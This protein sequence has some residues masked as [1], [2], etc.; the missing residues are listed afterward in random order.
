MLT[1]TQTYIYTYT[2]IYTCDTNLSCG[3]AHIFEQHGERVS[4]MNAIAVF[5]IDCLSQ[6]RNREYNPEGFLCMS[7]CVYV[8]VRACGQHVANTPGEPS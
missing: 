3:G 7:V 6:R 2:Y 1:Y 8:C 5:G 4:E